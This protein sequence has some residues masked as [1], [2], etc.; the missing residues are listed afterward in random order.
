M[1]TIDRIRQ[2]LVVGVAELRLVRLIRSNPAVQRVILG[3][4]MSCSNIKKEY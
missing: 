2:D 4:V 1:V 3:V